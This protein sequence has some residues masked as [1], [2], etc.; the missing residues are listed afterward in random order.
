MHMHIRHMDV[1]TSRYKH[2]CIHRFTAEEARTCVGNRSMLFAGDSLVLLYNVRVMLLIKTCDA[3]D[4]PVMF[5]TQVRHVFVSLASLL[6]EQAAPAPAAA[7]VNVSE[8]GVNLSEVGV[9]LSE[10]H[11]RLE[12]A[13][14]G[15]LLHV[16]EGVSAAEAAEIRH[17]VCV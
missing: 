11:A 8:V 6:L 13:R 7:G 5:L 2:V 14:A 1:N 16:A 17:C 12:E 3:L 10:T 15:Q 9:N 4:S